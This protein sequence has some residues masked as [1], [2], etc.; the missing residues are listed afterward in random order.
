MVTVRKGNAGFTLTE[1]MVVVVILSLLAALSTPLFGRDNNARKG[2]DW[3][4]IVAQLLQRARF[5]AMGDRA[6]MHVVLS[7]AQ[8]DLY[9]ED[10]VGTY[11]LLSST[12]GPLAD[13]EVERTVAI[14]DAKVNDPTT[15]PTQRNLP[16]GGAVPSVSV[17]ARDIIFTSVGNAVKFSDKTTPADWRVYLRNEL[18]PAGHPDS[19]FIIKIS[20]LTGFISSNDKV[21]LRMT[22]EP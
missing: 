19:S 2:R 20:G 7:R 14:W 17:E 11:T 12:L 18:L 13:S 10:P 3:A 6:N 1:L 5:Q 15:L 16:P 9:R 21:T 22:G 8:V 4:K